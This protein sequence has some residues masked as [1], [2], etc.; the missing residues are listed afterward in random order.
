MNKTKNFN[1]LIIITLL[2]GCSNDHDNSGNIL[3]PAT[4]T[5]ANTVGC[6]VNGEVFLPHQEGISP[7][8]V[9]NY[10][11]VDGE[12]FFLL[13]F[14]DLRGVISEFVSV[15]TGFTELQANQTYLLDKNPDDDGDYIGGGGAYR[16]NTLSD[17]EYYTNNSITGE[18]TITRLDLSNSITSGTFWFD[19]VNDQGEIVEIRDGR[20]DYVY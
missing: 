3:P 6:L 12:F 7:A 20:F 1:L 5:G 14:A 13:N 8:V 4:Q 18:L 19:A 11:F 10:E 17:G 16:P 15:R 9:V 2:I